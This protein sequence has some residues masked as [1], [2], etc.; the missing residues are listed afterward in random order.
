[1][2]R[3]FDD[4][5]RRKVILELEKHFNIKLKPIGK[6]KKF[7]QANDGYK[8][9]VLG[10]WGAWHGIPKSIINQNDAEIQSTKLIFAKKSLDQISLFFAPFA[11]LVENKHKLT[12]NKQGD[13]HFNLVHKLKGNN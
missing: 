7:F 9:C 13:Y 5:D 1:M 8:Y 11:P 6:F 3:K 10:G 2:K 4:T 12:V